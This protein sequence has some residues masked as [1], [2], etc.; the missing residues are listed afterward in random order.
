MTNQRNKLLI[1]PYVRLLLLLALMFKCSSIMS[2]TTYADNWETTNLQV[3]PAYP[4]K[5]SKNY[6]KSSWKHSTSFLQCDRWKHSHQSDYRSSDI[7]VDHILMLRWILKH[8][9]QDNHKLSWTLIYTE[10]LY[11][12]R[13]RYIQS[14]RLHWFGYALRK[15]PTELAKL[16]LDM[17]SWWSN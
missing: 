10:E 3:K 6:Y 11:P 2:T 7:C 14:L 16:Q 1:Q 12:G 9:C 15:L 4:Q 8:R 13:G 17:S 5:F